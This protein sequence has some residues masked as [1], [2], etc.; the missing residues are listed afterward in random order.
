[1]PSEKEARNIDIHSSE[2]LLLIPIQKTKRKYISVLN[3][4]T[5]QKRNQKEEMIFHFHVQS[6]N[7]R[8]VFPSKNKK[9]PR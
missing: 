7:Q 2:A 5:G 4:P 1:L 9:T 6:I 8:F 3:Y